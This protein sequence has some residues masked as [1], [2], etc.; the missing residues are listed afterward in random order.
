MGISIKGSL[1]ENTDLVD[2]ADPSTE[3]GYYGAV[4][5]CLQAAPRVLASGP[6]WLGPVRPS[7]HWAPDLRALAALPAHA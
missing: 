7:I 4:A 2:P 5:T 3:P 6:G 1:V